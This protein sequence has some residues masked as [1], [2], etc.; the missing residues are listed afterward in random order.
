MRCE[1]YGILKSFFNLRVFYCTP[2]LFGPF[3]PL[4]T[5]A[6]QSTYLICLYSLTL[7]LI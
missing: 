7:N 5:V 3:D 1:T 6:A 4:P 2:N